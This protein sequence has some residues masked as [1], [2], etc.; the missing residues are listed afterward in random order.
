MASRRL[1]RRRARE[2]R[3]AEK[4]RIKA[5]HKVNTLV[6][7]QSPEAI[8]AFQERWN[9]ENPGQRPLATDGVAGHWTRLAMRRA[10]EG[11]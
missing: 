4:R 7:L 1:R 5:E 6:R 3:I 2:Q 11:V 9:N 8:R 10:L